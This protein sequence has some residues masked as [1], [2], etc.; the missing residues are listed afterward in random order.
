[1]TNIFSPAELL[2]MKTGIW[3]VWNAIAPDC[4]G[5][6]DNHDNEAAIEMCVDCDR[7]VTF[8]RNPDAGKIR[9]EIFHRVYMAN[10]SSDVYKELSKAIQLV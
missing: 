5:L 4:E 7:L 10:K 8:A 1:M 6:F 3:E 9:Q 2:A